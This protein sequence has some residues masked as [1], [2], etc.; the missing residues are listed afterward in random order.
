MPFYKWDPQLLSVHVGPMDDEHQILIKK[1]NSLYDAHARK[2]PKAELEKLLKDFANYT[3]E[4]FKDEEKYMES[5]AYKGI[6]SHK[7]IHKK[8]LG[9]VSTY[10][11]EFGKTGALT[12][13]FFRFL[14]AWLTT[15]IRGIDMKYG[16]NS[17]KAAA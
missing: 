12:D 1:M 7:L 9:Q 14:G 2:A 13:A 15:H 16:E 10:V 11:E 5:I 8:L 17:E 6:D 4:H 3:V